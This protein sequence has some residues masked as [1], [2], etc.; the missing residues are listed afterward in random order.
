MF[1]IQGSFDDLEQDGQRQASFG[2]VTA[3][4]FF[5]LLLVSMFTLTLLAALTLG[6][7]GQFDLTISTDHSTA[8]NPADSGVQS[9]SSYQQLTAEFVVLDGTAQ[10]GLAPLE[11]PSIRVGDNQDV[12]PNISLAINLPRPTSTQDMVRREAMA[13]WNSLDS[14]TFGSQP[15]WE[16][17]ITIP[18]HEPAHAP[19]HPPTNS[20]SVYN[21][22]VALFAR[23]SPE[24]VTRIRQLVGHWRNADH[25][26]VSQILFPGQ[27]D[28]CPPDVLNQL[29]IVYLR[30]NS[31]GNVRFR[32]QVVQRQLQKHEWKLVYDPR[33]DRVTTHGT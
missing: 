7:R 12:E 18:A 30:W 11:T 8:N 15:A 33:S 4:D 29:A 24:R 32:Y 17:K 6:V 14:P 19:S 28:R 31:A 2:G 26:G 25:I 16:V 3:T 13:S 21:S 27:N 1:D 23:T 20:D 22:L 10:R 9:A 5:G